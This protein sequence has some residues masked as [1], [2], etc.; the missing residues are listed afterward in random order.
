MR[1]LK[2]M[3]FFL[4]GFMLVACSSSGGASLP[5]SNRYDAQDDPVSHEYHCATDDNHKGPCGKE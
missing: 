2:T 3:T 4:M 1:P 5:F